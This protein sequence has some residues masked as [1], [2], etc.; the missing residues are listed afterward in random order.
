MALN[1]DEETDVQR[2][3]QQLAESTGS[4]VA[5][6]AVGSLMSR[7]KQLDEGIARQ[8]TGSQGVWQGVEWD[9]KFLAYSGPLESLPLIEDE[10]F[11]QKF[12]EILER[13]GYT[14][15]LSDPARLS[16]RIEQGYRIIHLTDRQSWRRRIGRPA[17]VLIAKPK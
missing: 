10:V 9:G 12:A 8:T 14:V 17:E 13:N 5:D 3:L 6:S 2:L 16:S 4:R 15:R 7:L 11:Q 1:C